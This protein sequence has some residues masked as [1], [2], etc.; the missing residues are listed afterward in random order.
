VLPREITYSQRAV[1]RETTPEELHKAVEHWLRFSSCTILES[2]PPK[3][4]KAYFPAISGILRLGL[5]DE[6]PKNIEVIIGSF[7]SSATMN[8]TFTQ[9]ITR[10]GE[11]GFLYWGDRLEQLYREL[12]VPLDPY[13]LTQLYPTPWVQRVLSRTLRI[14]AA[15]LLLSLAV[16]ALG[17]ELHP[18]L[19]ATYFF[20]V[21]LPGTFMAGLEYRDHWE[22]LKKTGVK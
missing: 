12:G 16:V 8:I 18:D 1:A 20:I 22:L 5:R 14:Y 9:E 21:V 10:M 11:S 4:I 13:T 17:L 2:N 15:F 6:N 19:V 3:S 7:G